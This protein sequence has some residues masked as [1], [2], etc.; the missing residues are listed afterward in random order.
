MNITLY[1]NSEEISDDE[2]KPLIDQL[3]SNNRLVPQEAR[4]KLVNLGRKAETS[5]IRTL[6]AAHSGLRWEAVVVLGEIGD[7]HPTL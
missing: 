4:R 1:T 2:W 7:P 3:S 5:L 6:S